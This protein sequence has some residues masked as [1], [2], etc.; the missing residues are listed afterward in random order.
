MTLPLFRKQAVDHQREKLYGDIILTQPISYYVLAAFLVG[1]TIIAI[2]FLVTHSYARKE[3]VA[4]IIV[5][6][7]GMVPVFPPQAGILTELNV[8][9]GLPVKYNDELFS[10]M[11]D[12]R[13]NGGEYIGVKIIDELKVQE[14]NLNKRL[15]FENERV[16]TE[17]QAQEA[18]ARRLKTEI[19]RLKELIGIQAETLKMEKNNY[20]KAK[21][22]LSEEFISNIDVE[23]FYRKYL[24]QKQQYQSLSMRMEEAVSSL[25][26]IPL[27]I[28]A[29]KINSEREIAGI[30]SQISEITKQRAQV[31]GQR[32]IIFTAPVSG[33]ITSVV[34]NVGQRMNPSVPMFSII[35]E[36]S[37]LQA[38]LYLPTRS[39]GF[40]EMG[41]EVNISYEAF[42]YQKFGTYSGEIRQIAK[43]VIMPGEPASGLSFQEPV[44]KVIAELEKQN[45]LAYGKELPLK[46]GMMLSADVVLDK[47][48]LFEWLLEP[49]YSLRG[50]I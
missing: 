18:E 37:Q 32:E 27:H 4:G 20:E 16:A 1:I 10:I 22:M 25:E 12:Q 2:F 43:S 42:P 6:Q 26:N 3:K 31:E 38:N 13:A 50:K 17:I 8:T 14:A 19:E 23:T 45:I 11:I 46:P 34:A 44:Y 48:T 40:M 28:K 9:E 41:Q 47:R 24:E 49:L 7:Q 15:K 33:R 21:T 29:L 36:G 39:I 30:E 5:P 35:P